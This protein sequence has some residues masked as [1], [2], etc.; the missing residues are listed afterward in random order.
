MWVCMC[1]STY[2]YILYI[3]IYSMYMCI[4]NKYAYTSCILIYK[5]INYVCSKYV[6]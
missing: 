1:I 4:Y 6:F 2:V 5:H 3:H